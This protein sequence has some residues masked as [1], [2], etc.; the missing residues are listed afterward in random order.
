MF[1][2][3]FLF[4]TICQNAFI[5]LLRYVKIVY[6][7]MLTYFCRE[8]MKPKKTDTGSDHSSGSSPESSIRTSPVL[9][10]GG[11]AKDERQAVNMIYGEKLKNIAE[12]AQYIHICLDIMSRR[13]KS[14]K[15]LNAMQYLLAR[16]TDRLSHL[17]SNEF[18]LYSF[19]IK[20]ASP[21]PIQVIRNGIVHHDFDSFSD[22]KFDYYHQLLTKLSAF[23][24]LNVYTK[25]E[26]INEV[27]ENPIRLKFDRYKNASQIYAEQEARHIGE[28]KAYFSEENEN[29]TKVLNKETLR[30]LQR[31]FD[32]VY[33]Y[34]N[35]IDVGWLD[36]VDIITKTCG[37]L[38]I[39]IAKAG[40]IF[41]QLRTGAGGKAVFTQMVR[42]GKLEIYQQSIAGPANNPLSIIQQFVNVRRAV[43][44]PDEPL[45]CDVVKGVI[46]YV[47]SI[48]TANDKL[49]HNRLSA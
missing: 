20:S 10:S 11:P 7:Y 22:E 42:E 47:R 23:R 9:L 43:Y 49:C 27:I 32:L 40:E 46:G 6:V 14:E 39:S 44:H 3:A 18:F 12:D 19:L 2:Q 29:R 16:I 35:D 13:T 30:K 1:F 15:M 48:K 4:V 8:I 36:N 25:D 38:L 45:N 24:V 5:I 26:I 28:R 34:S 41:N 33:E 17:Y 37:P 31:Q 21:D